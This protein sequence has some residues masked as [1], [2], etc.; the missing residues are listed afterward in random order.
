M[1]PPCGVVQEE[2][3]RQGD[4]REDEIREEPEALSTMEQPRQLRLD[5]QFAWL[6]SL[7][8][9]TR[10]RTAK[11]RPA[12]RSAGRKQAG[13]AISGSSGFFNQP[14][15]DGLDRNPDSLG[16][17]VG[18]LDSDPLQVRAEHALG[19][20]G[21]MGADSPALLG[22]S[23]AI[24]DRTLDGAATG[25]CADSGHGGIDVV[26]GSQE[27]CARRRSKGIF[28]DSDGRRPGRVRAGHAGSSARMEDLEFLTEVRREK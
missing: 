20:A 21:N 19:D 28:P 5:L 27:R 7:C 13:D 2:G 3:V 11:K 26:K 14:G 17:S 6:N 1:M 4:Q 8:L 18:H 15:F 12:G 16:A 10:A 24:D 25:D 9:A 23:L 22:L